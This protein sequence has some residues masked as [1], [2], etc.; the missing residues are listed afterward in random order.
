MSK[1]PK[2]AMYRGDELLGIGTAC[3]LAERFG[4]KRKTV[5]WYAYSACH[6]RT[7][8]SP[9]RIYATRIEDANE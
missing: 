3:E 7:N 2:Y 8:G 5:M 4:I 1:V 6:K 9:N